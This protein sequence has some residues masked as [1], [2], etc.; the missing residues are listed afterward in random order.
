MRV[1]MSAGEPSGDLHG[2]NLIRAIL[3]VDP[4]ADGRGFHFD[5][6][7]LVA[8]QKISGALAQAEGRPRRGFTRG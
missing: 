3:A 2:A 6:P 4:G 7:R 1:F 5:L 8:M